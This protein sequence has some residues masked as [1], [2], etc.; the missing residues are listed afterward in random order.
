MFTFPGRCSENKLFPKCPRQKGA[1]T[2][3]DFLPEMYGL[4]GPYM[5]Y[6]VIK[7]A[8]SS[9]PPGLQVIRKVYFFS[10]FPG[11]QFIKKVCF[12]VL[13]GLQ[14][15]K[16]DR[17][18]VFPSSQVTNMDFLFFNSSKFPG[19][20]HSFFCSPSMFTIPGFQPE[21]K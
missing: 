17:C 19:H 9:V 8:R 1:F 3:M 6:Q 4:Y 15:I 7:K 13:P 5:D 21:S 20:Q 14:A 16:M 12:A 18:S 11:S 10:V 2:N